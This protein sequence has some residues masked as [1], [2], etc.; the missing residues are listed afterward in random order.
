MQKNIRSIL[1]SRKYWNEY[2][3]DRN[4]MWAK[5]HNVHKEFEYILGK[6]PGFEGKFG[7]S[8]EVGKR[9]WGGHLPPASANIRN[10]S[11]YV[12]SLNNAGIKTCTLSSGGITVESGC[13]IIE[14]VL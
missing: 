13:K 11:Y 10:F 8:R 4:D 6:V 3:Y 1:E 7:T 14:T 12:T 2:C 5:A 9:F